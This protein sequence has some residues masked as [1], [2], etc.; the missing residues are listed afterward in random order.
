MGVFDRSREARTFDATLPS[1]GW[2]VRIRRANFRDCVLS[3][4]IPLGA[5]DQMEARAKKI[6]AGDED[7]LMQ[8][9]PEE[10]QRMQR[11]NQEQV[12]RS[13]IQV[14]HEDVAPT[15]ED[16]SEFD[17]EDYAQLQRW[18]LRQDE[19]QLGKADGGD[20]VDE[21]QEKVSP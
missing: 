17:D 19:P 2:H 11:V 13:I 8:T 14:Q 15:L 9:P 21:P 18:V 3:A 7:A 12:R 5:I 20:V 4:G 16:L 10:L 1:S 6:R